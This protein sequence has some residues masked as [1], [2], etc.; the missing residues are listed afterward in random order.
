MLKEP[1][2]SHF[3]SDLTRE[4]IEK[5]HGKATRLYQRYMVN[6][7]YTS[8]EAAFH[9]IEDLSRYFDDS[10]LNKLIIVGTIFNLAPDKELHRY[11]ANTLFEWKEIV[12]LEGTLERVMEL[13]ESSIVSTENPYLRSMEI[14]YN[15]VKE[16]VRT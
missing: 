4:N 11:I 6:Y 1:F 3:Y 14:S 8:E 12:D 7:A 16:F 9:T 15:E 10:V 13:T 5:L 2:H